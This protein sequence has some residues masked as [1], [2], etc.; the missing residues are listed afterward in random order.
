MDPMTRLNLYRPCLF[1]ALASLALGAQTADPLWAKAQA[2]LQ[3]A[4]RLYASEITTV[5]ELHDTDG[6]SMGRQETRTRASGWKDG[7]PV[8]TVVSHTETE[9]MPADDGAKPERVANHPEQGLADILTVQRG[10][11]AREG[12]EDCAVFQVTG[13]RKGKAPFTGQ[14]WIEKVNG[15]PVKAWF[16][17][18]TAHIPMT[19]SMTSFLQFIHAQD[20]CLPVGTT[21]DTLMSVMFMKV[22][23]TIQSSYSTWV[24]RP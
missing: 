19:R 6:K 13:N 16:T 8:R 24:A 4:S 18:D 10:A 12:S 20:A 15:F 9:H 3:A 21:V 7:E 11:D 2:H 23:M 22:R 17:F 5:M 14:V 1:W